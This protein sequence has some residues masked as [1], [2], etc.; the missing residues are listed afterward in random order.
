MKISVLEPH[1]FCF[2]VQ[3]ALKTALES[4]ATYCFHELVHNEVVISDLRNRGMVFVDSIQDVPCGEKVLF[5]AHGVSPAIRAEAEQRNLDVIDATCPFVKRVHKQV[6]SAAKRDVPVVI[7]GH[8]N[9]VEVQGVAGEA[10]DKVTIIQSAE[11]VE[12]LTYDEAAPVSVV[13]QT[14]LGTDEVSDVLDALRKRYKLLELSPATEVCTATRDRQQAVKDFV[15][16]G[17]DAVL[18]LGSLNSSNTNRLVEIACAEGA[19]ALRAGVIED[20]EKLDFSGI[21]HLGVTSGA[22][23]PESFLNKVLEKIVE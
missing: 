12:L 11:E 22:S 6:I 9:H 23:T 1:G 8:A 15:Q 14:T 10:P 19:K 18:V 3:S 7:V 5:S 20:L 4:G 2:G 21:K 13:T 16:A 17:G